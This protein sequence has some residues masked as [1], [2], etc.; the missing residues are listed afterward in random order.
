MRAL[1]ERMEGDVAVVYRVL[2][3]EDAVLRDEL[4]ELERERGIA[5]HVVAGDHATEEGARLLSPEHLR[6]LVPDVAERDVYVCGPPA[7]TAA[8]ERTVRAAGIPH[9]RVHIERFAF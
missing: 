7:M 9:R 2:R 4:E 1:A 8:I 3:D 5:L 6:E